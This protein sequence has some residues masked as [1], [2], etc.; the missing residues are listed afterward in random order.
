M[1]ILKDN[2]IQVQRGE[3]IAVSVASIETFY[4]VNYVLDGEPGALSEDKSLQ[5]TVETNPKNLVLRCG[6]SGRGGR[7][8]IRLKGSKGEHVQEIFPTSPGQADSVVYFSFLP[9][10]PTTDL[11]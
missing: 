6:F 9:G 3:V 11:P 4:D 2:V 1:K 5:L 7:Y 10:E 8:R